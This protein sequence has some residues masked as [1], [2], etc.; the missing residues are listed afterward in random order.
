MDL[1]CAT[2]YQTATMSCPLRYAYSCMSQID[3]THAGEPITVLAIDDDA[4]ALRLLAEMLRG[5]EF[6]LVAALDAMA[7]IE[8]ARQS[9][10]SIVL[11]DMMMPLM[12]GEKAI[13][14]FKQELQLADVPVLFVTASNALAHKLRA[15]ELGAVDYIT[16]P[17]SPEEVLARLRVHVRIRQQLQATS[18]ASA[19]ESKPLATSVQPQSAAERMVRQAQA[20]LLKDLSATPTLVELAHAVG[21]N[22]RRLTE[23][24][25]R[26]TGKPVFEYLREERHRLASEQLLHSHAPIGQIAQACG[27]QGMAAFTF[28]FRRRFGV[29]PSEYRAN[30][31]LPYALAASSLLAS[32]QTQAL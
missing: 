27:Y 20:L 18:P 2:R 1:H 17:F 5:S 19:V 31:G 15:F 6:R 8:R 30:A 4:R 16:K 26:Y 32:T 13:Q 11:M 9:A 23:E 10:P 3:T 25:R 24:F 28:A 21:T 22:E 12:D 29:S 14:A 7:G